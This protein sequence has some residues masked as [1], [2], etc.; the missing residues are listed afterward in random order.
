MSGCTHAPTWA[1]RR[2]GGRSCTA[3]PQRSAPAVQRTQRSGT[4]FHARGVQQQAGSYWVSISPGAQEVLAGTFFTAAEESEDRTNRT[5]ALCR[6]FNPSAFGPSDF[7]LLCTAQV[8][9]HLLLQLFLGSLQVLDEQVL[10]AYMETCN[11]GFGRHAGATWTSTPTSLST[12]C[13]PLAESFNV[14][15]LLPWL[16]PSGH[17]FPAHG[18]CITV[19]RHAWC[20]HL[21]SS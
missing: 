5:Q 2:S 17:A 7:L 8:P 21:V 4:K 6:T 13:G 19:T 11:N 3:W 12:L 14:R 18:E 9:P 10:P 15:V 20:T 16:A 1:P